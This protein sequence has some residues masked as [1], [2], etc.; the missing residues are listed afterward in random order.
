MKYYPDSD[1]YTEKGRFGG[2]KPEQ[3]EQTSFGRGVG[4]ILEWNTPKMF[5]FQ[6][7]T[8]LRMFQL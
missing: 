4:D 6:N 5:Q 7:G 2:V 1:N 8:L 3:P